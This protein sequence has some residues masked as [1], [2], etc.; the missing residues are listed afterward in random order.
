MYP[1]TTTLV[2]S[3]SMGPMVAMT[4]KLPRPSAPTFTTVPILHVPS[5]SVTF[6]GKPLHTSEPTG[7][8]TVSWVL[9]ARV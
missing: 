6:S 5:T 4:S 9:I 3:T 2:V 7:T 8:H 1:N